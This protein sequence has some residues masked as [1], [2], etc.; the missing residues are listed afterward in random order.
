MSET[1]L[2]A[3]FAARQRRQVFVDA[4]LLAGCAGVVYL[5]IPETGDVLFGGLGDVAAVFGVIGAAVFAT[6]ENWRCPACD[7]LLGASIAPKQCRNCGTSFPRRFLNRD[8]SR[9]SP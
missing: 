6:F 8:G 1:G 3:K 7:G 4:V 9:R 2:R 5:A